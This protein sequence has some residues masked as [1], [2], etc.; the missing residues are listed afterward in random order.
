MNPFI[1]TFLCE[2]LAVEYTGDEAANV[3]RFRCHAKV[4]SFPS[5]QKG[6]SVNGHWFVYRAIDEKGSFELS[7]LD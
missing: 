6:F 2:E 4:W 1:L 3:V 7:A 5:R